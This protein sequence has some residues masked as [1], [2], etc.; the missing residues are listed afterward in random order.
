[1]NCELTSWE[2]HQLTDHFLN[3]RLWELRLGM[4]VTGVISVSS[5]VTLIADRFGLALPALAWDILCA[6][7][8]GGCAAVVAAWREKRWILLLKKVKR[9]LVELEADTN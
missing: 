1:M 6:G 9:R 3:E 4:A 2:R 8:I 5:A 7:A